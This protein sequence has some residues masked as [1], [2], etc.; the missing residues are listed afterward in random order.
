[1]IRGFISR[2]DGATLTARVQ[3]TITVAEKYVAE[4]PR[5]R[6][7][8]LATRDSLLICG[9]TGQ[10]GKDEDAGICGALYQT[11]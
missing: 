1:M 11:D 6:G 10:A 4:T 2:G 8:E 7:L 3:E 5:P 9:I